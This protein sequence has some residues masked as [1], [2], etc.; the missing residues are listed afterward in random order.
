MSLYLPLNPER[1][2]PD[3]RE[4][5]DRWFQTASASNVR[6]TMEIV[7]DLVGPACSAVVDPFAGGGSSATAARLMDLPFF[8][9][10]IDPVLACVSLA[11]SRATVGHARILQRLPPIRD[12]ES[13]LSVL[14]LL[15]TCASADEVAVASCL[16]VVLA[17]RASRGTPLGY[18]EITGDLACHR[19][20]AA[21]GRLVCADATVPASWR[22][23][24][25]P[26]E[27][28]V[29][30]TSPQFGRRSPLLGAPPRL[31]ATARGVLASVGGD[32]GR[33]TTPEDSGF[34][35]TTV[36]MLR[37]AAAVMRRA[38]VVIE[39]EP[40][41]D[42]HNATEE[43]LERTAAALPG[44]VHNARFIFCGQFTW[45]GPLS[46]IVFDLR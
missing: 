4:P 33:S 46:L 8:G 19:R 14:A 37:Q 41:D 40:D 34:A 10:E 18:Q 42:G 1:Y 32:H 23:L 12:L 11:K 9:I 16:A 44:R 21:T 36:A 27:D 13:L 7:A 24:P 28:A 20:P 30:Y 3:P 2:H 38:T 29:L 35:G 22:D 17:L 26:Q 39:H 45:R 15:P 43:T 5:V 6:T 31:T 25:V